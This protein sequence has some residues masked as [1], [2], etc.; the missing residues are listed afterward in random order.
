MWLARTALGGCLLVF[1]TS[2]TLDLP[3]SCP[4][5]L[6]A[7]PY[8]IGDIVVAV[9]GPTMTPAYCSG[10][11]PQTVSGCQP[12]DGECTMTG[13]LVASTNPPT[14]TSWWH[15]TDL[16]LSA[17]CGDHSDWFGEIDPSGTHSG[18]VNIFLHC[19]PCSPDF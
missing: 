8:A 6:K 7:R 11:N 5:E 3:C 19:D 15:V 14:S 2:T 13:E 16:D 10:F 4:P 1:T 17:G 12:G 18:L 9:L